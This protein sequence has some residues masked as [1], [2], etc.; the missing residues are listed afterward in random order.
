M[1]QEIPGT[2]EATG[3]RVS[4]VL[5]VFHQIEPLRRALAALDKSQERERIEVLVLDCGSEDGTAEIDSEFSSISVLR[6][7]HHLG[8]AKAMNIGIRTAKA[9]LVMFL[10]PDVEVLPDTIAGLAARLEQDTGAAG[11]C[12]LLVNPAGEPTPKIFRYPTRETFASGD[13]PP[14]NLNLE[15]E[16]I[17]VEYPS[18]AA[19]LIR[20]Q[21]IRT[22]NFFDEHYGEYWADADVA[23]KVRQAGKKIR[24][25]PSIRAVLHPGQDPLAGDALAEADRTLGA[26]QY[27]GKYEGFFSGASFRLTAVLKALLSFNFRRFSLLLSG[28]KLDGTQTG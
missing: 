9:E 20:R 4:V 28:Q 3:P 12:P 5:V 25:Y 17:A 2:E 11:A 8:S 22:I 26:A 18:R 7:P 13:L 14:M 6:L 16:S 15:Q 24:L 1:A 19:L 21:F 10:A 27:L 23:M